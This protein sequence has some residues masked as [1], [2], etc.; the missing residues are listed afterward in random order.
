[1]PRIKK[2]N[3]KDEDGCLKKRTGL[4][5]ESQRISNFGA[6]LGTYS[7]ITSLHT[8]VGYCFVVVYFL[9]QPFLRGK[10]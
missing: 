2:S 1:M 8:S 9:A 6:I 10:V 4:C 3:A 5:D 7:V